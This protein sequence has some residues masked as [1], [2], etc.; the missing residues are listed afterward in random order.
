MIISNA[1]P[2]IGLAKLNLIGILGQLYGKV[3]MPEA[4]FDEVVI[5][6][7]QRGSLDALAIRLATQRKELIV[8]AVK[9]TRDC[10][11]KLQLHRGEKEVIQLA[12]ENEASLLLMDD[13]LAREQASLLGFKVKG[14]LGIIVDA[15]RS[16]ILTLDEAC[17]AIEAIIHRQDIWISTPLCLKVLEHLKK[18]ETSNLKVGR[19]TTC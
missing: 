17:M 4:V 18:G 15:Y 16:Q 7:I 6:G 14:T 1:G 11:E 3:F 8:K 2:L 5:G 13:M 10:I 19:F 12:F 9:Q